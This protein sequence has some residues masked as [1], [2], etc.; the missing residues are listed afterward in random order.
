MWG[1]KDDGKDEEKVQLA[2]EK[3]VAADWLMD[4]RGR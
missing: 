3:P 4:E 2:C 1:E